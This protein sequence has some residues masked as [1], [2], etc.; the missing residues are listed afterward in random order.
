LVAVPLPIKSHSCTDPILPVLTV[1]PAYYGTL[2]IYWRTA[3]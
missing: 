3:L 1:M 2:E